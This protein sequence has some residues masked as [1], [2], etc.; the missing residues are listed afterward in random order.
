MDL[1]TP[2]AVP[3]KVKTII[4]MQSYRQ[5]KSIVLESG[6]VDK[7]KLPALQLERVNDRRINSTCADRVIDGRED[8][9]LESS[10]DCTD[11]ANGEGVEIYNHLMLT[12][13]ACLFFCHR[14]CHRIK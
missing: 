6:E 13:K 2:R 9:Q 8:R 10:Q 14:E 7:E 3:S 4:R 11:I 12:E 5:I 1:L